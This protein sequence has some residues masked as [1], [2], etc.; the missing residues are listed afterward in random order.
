MV[1]RESGVVRVKCGGRGKCSTRLSKPTLEGKGNT[2]GLHAC[3]H[4]VISSHTTHNSAKL[5]KN[6]TR[7]LTVHHRHDN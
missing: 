3:I 7:L 4:A 1:Q 2:K 5:F 6:F